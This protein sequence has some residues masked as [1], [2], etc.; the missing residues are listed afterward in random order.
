LPIIVSIE[1]RDIYFERDTINVIRYRG[2]VVNNIDGLIII[3]LRLYP[4]DLFKVSVIIEYSL[5]LLVEVIR[6]Y[7]LS[8][9]I[10]YYDLT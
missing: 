4:S 5:E 6:S 9:I 10:I 8:Y 1:I 7:L 2:L 3:L